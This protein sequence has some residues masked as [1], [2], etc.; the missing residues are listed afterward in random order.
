MVIKKNPTKKSAKKYYDGHSKK[1]INFYSKSYTGY[2]D[3][4]LRLKII[5]NQ[6]KKYKIK[7]IFDL[8]CGSG[9]PMIELLKKKYSVEGVDFSEEMVKEGKKELERN[10]FN[11]NLIKHG[12]IE[13]I[14]S[15]PKKKYDAVIA[16][17]VFP[18][19]LNEKKTLINIKKIL[20]PKGKIF[21][22]FKNELFSAFTLNPY[23]LDF[24]LNDLVNVKQFSPKIKKDVINY[25]EK[26]FDK[27]ISK[28]TINDKT[29]DTKILSKFHNPLKVK[30]EFFQSSGYHVDN[31]LFYHYHAMPPIF[32]SK[33]P[34]SFKSESLKL[35]NPFDW[36]GYL[37]SS[38]FIIE[39]TKK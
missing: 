16:L 34:E 36:R 39:A 32:E 6:L 13:N 38:A 29:P 28:N 21:I 2:P 14:K 31:I 12:D 5:I 35:E 24:F 27:K 7:T 23:S 37:M 4:E 15:L 3:Q 30:E 8:G 20:K 22:M 17:G 18:H 11:S 10:G 33:Y 25:F 1:W 26:K 19:I 9:G